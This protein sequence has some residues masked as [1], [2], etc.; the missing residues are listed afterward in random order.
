M[1]IRPG[2]KP[3]LWLNFGYQPVSIAYRDFLYLRP[4]ISVKRLQLLP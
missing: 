2:I 3:D 4:D 1:K